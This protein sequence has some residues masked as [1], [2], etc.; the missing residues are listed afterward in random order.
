MCQLT[1]DKKLHLPTMTHFPLD[2]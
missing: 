2:W 1:C